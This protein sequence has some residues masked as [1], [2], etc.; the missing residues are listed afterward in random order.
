MTNKVGIHHTLL[1][2][3]NV[4]VQISGIPRSAPNMPSLAMSLRDV[5]GAAALLIFAAPTPSDGL[6]FHSPAPPPAPPSKFPVGTIG[7]GTCGAVY[8]AGS[9]A[10]DPVGYFEGVATMAACAAKV[11]ACPKAQYASWSSLD[12]SCAWYSSC[13]MATL[14][15]DCSAAG[16]CAVP[17]N[18]QCPSC[19]KSCPHYWPH[20][21]EVVRAASPPSPPPPPPPPGPMPAG[22]Y[23]NDAYG[24]VS[25]KYAPGNVFP[26]DANHPHGLRLVD[27]PAHCCALCQTYKNCTFWTYSGGG[28]PAHPTCYSFSGACCFLKTD[29]AKGLDQPDKAGVVSGSTKPYPPLPTGPLTV[30]V[31]WTTEVITTQTAATVEVDVMPFLGEADWGGPFEAYKTALGNLDSEFV[32]FAPWFA[33]PRV[34]V[35]ELTPHTCTATQPSTNWNSTYFDGVMKDFMEA[36]CGPN[37]AKG[38]CTH[39]VVQQLSTMPEYMYIGGDAKPLPAYPWN[40]TDPFDAYKAGNA[41]VDPTCKQMARYFGRLVG[42]YTNGGFTDE[43]GHFHPSEFHYDWWGISVLNEDE[44]GIQPENG[45]A[46]TTCYDAI[47][48]EVEK[49]NKKVTLVGPEIVG[50]SFSWGYMEYFLKAENHAD[51]QASIYITAPCGAQSVM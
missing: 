45:P 5:A 12:H 31:D 17:H 22:C 30:T 11:M 16:S 48:I 35:P 34:V 7:N 33:N 43:C 20:T 21:S 19:D 44:H 36:V 24:P 8:I 50:G 15:V 37:A 6:V 47:K 29:A 49:V 18:P 46:Y 2:N 41:L 25:Y 9:C 38:T 13:D 26:T 51:K 23:V 1:V 4:N 32:R 39:S 40:T 10:T 14:C 42:W 3:V 28:T 27:S